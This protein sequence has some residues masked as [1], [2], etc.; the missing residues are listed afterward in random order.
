[1]LLELGKVDDDGFIKYVSDERK[2]RG[3]DCDVVENVL[4]EYIK[5][6]KKIV[7]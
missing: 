2:K 6:R 5:R 3:S 4:S 7:V 1:M